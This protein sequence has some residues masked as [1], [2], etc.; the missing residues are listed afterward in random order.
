MTFNA[1]KSIEMWETTDGKAHSKF[2][3][4]RRHQVYLD[5]IKMLPGGKVDQA[6]YFVIMELAS[7]FDFVKRETI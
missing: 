1:P 5:V 4:A 2:E 3:T 6:G 7:Q